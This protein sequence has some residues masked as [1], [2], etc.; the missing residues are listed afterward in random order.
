[1]LQVRVVPAAIGAQ[2]GQ[3]VF[4]YFPSMPGNSTCHVQ[5]K[6]R[7]QRGRMPDHFFDDSQDCACRMTT[8]S[9]LMEQQGICQIDLLKVAWLLLHVPG[10]DGVTV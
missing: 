2:E 7:L 3:V 9:S 4:R 1:M 6:E 5:E 8:V 10:V